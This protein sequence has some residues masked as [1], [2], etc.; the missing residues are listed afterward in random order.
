MYSEANGGS[1]REIMTRF[2]NGA[3]L[4]T[5]KGKYKLATGEVQSLVIARASNR[6]SNLLPI[7]PLVSKSSLIPCKE[8]AGHNGVVNDAI[9]GGEVL[10]AA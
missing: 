9:R 10:C 2:G 6:L 1:Q 4:R 5:L 8:N 3:R 7:D